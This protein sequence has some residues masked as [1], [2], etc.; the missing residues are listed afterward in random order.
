MAGII[1][2][3]GLY[4]PMENSGISRKISLS[5]GMVTDSPSM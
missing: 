2:R 3:V 4:S 1:D 5:V